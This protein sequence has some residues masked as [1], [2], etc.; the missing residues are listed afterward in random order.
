M[1]RPC[2]IDVLSIHLKVKRRNKPFEHA[3]RDHTRKRGQ[4]RHADPDHRLF[5]IACHG[6]SFCIVKITDNRFS[7]SKK[8]SPIGS[9]RTKLVVA[10]L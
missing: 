9:D 4:R 7:F 8:F 5:E 10:Q 3:R 1:I 2:R 6:C